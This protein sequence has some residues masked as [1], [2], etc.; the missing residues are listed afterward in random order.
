MDSYDDFYD[1]WKINEIEFFFLGDGCD[2]I[3]LLKG[4]FDVTSNEIDPLFAREAGKN[5]SK[6]GV[7]LR[8]TSFDWRKIDS[9]LPHGSFD[10]VILLGNSLTYLFGRKARLRAL[11]AFRN[12]LKPGG[13]LLIDERNYTY[14]LSHREQILE[15]EFRY[16]G[17]Y[18]YCGN[19]VHAHPIE[20]SEN[21]VVMQYSHSDGTKA[22]L[23]MYPFKQGELKREIA[24][25]G[26]GRVR[27]YS[28]YSD[29]FRKKA[30]F[31]EYLAAK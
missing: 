6:A 25:A 19:K 21:K 30:D 14:I 18:V 8:I 12:I 9:G 7:K 29:G 2:S 28:D 11:A 4:G 22:Y 1:L 26:F 24:L 27:Q 3:Y 15:G 20:I 13:L 31:Y 5:A 16:S 17:R 23:Q 10:A